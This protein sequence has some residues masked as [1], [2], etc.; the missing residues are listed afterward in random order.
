MAT[1]Q[2]KPTI[3]GRIA[4]HYKYYTKTKTEMIN[5]IQKSMHW[6][7]LLMSL[8]KIKEPILTDF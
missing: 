2:Q 1:G 6:F 3:G 8:F 4:V 7:L 5:L